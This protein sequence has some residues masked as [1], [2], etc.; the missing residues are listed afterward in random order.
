MLERESEI[1]RERQRGREREQPQPQP[2]PH[3]TQLLGPRERRCVQNYI[4]RALV[5]DR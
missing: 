3:S 5:A 2:Q 1:E 4:N